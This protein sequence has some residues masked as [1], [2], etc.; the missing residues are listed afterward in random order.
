MG[1]AKTKTVPQIPSKIK[2]CPVPI[3]GYVKMRK[4]PHVGVQYLEHW[5]TNYYTHYLMCHPCLL[6]YSV[7]KYLLKVC[8]ISG[9]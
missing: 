7:Y 4:F 3:L 9:V 1:L 6:I 8:Y 2:Y 5:E